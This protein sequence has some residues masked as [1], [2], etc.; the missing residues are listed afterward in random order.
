MARWGA[1][2]LGGRHVKIT[3]CVSSV[4]VYPMT[5]FLLH[6][7]NVEEIEKQ[8]R[9]FFWYGKVGKRKYHLVKWKYVCRPRKKGG[10]GVKNIRLF[11]ICL[12]CKWWWRLEAEEGPWQVFV[13]KKYMKK[14]GINA[15]KQSRVI[16]P[17]GMI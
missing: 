5:M 3:A 9:A 6:R 12:L 1:L 2:S 11:N 13:R 8:T 4:A 10:L 17:A 16:L 15:V 7:S 14:G